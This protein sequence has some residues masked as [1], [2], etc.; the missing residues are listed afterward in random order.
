MVEKT[1]AASYLVML[2]L[3]M[4]FIEWPTVL[5]FVLLTMTFSFPLPVSLTLNQELDIYSASRT[6]LSFKAKQCSKQTFDNNVH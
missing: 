1:K 4:T 5:S 6:T 2:H 3:K